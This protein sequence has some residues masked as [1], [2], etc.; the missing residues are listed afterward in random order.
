MKY[1]IANFR[2][3]LSKV[4]S[5]ENYDKLLHSGFQVLLKDENRSIEETM[6]MVENYMKLLRE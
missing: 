2:E 4:N 6:Q 5:Q 3:C 1:A